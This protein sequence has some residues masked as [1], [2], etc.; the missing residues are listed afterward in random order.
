MQSLADTLLPNLQTVL[1]AGN[2]L[3]ELTPMVTVPDAATCYD[4]TAVP[5]PSV[6]TPAPVAPPV[7]ESQTTAGEGVLVNVAVRPLLYVRVHA[8]FLQALT[9]MVLVVQGCGAAVDA[10]SSRWSTSAVH[11]LSLVAM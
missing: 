4:L 1:L 2:G 7:A 5:A 6:N 8:A 9:V 3:G 11:D 10:D